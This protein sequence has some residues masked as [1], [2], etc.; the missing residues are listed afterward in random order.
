MWHPPG[1][2][3]VILFML[4]IRAINFILKKFQRECSAR[5]PGT[6]E[7]FHHILAYADDILLINRSAEDLQSL[8]HL[9]NVLAMKIELKFNPKTCITLHYSRKA[10]VGCRP[11]IFNLAGSQIPYV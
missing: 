3:T 10:P 6:M 9:I 8:L 2:G 7:L 4:F 5:D 1:S 11:T